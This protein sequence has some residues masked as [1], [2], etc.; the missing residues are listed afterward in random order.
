[1]S[2]LRPS[3]ATTCFTTEG[4]ANF[5]DVTAERGSW[6]VRP[7]QWSTSCAW[8][9][10]DN[11]GQLDLFVCNYVRWSRE[12]DR[13]SD[14]TARR[15]RPRLRAA[16][17]L[18]KARFPTFIATTATG[19]SPMSQRQSGVQIKNSAHRRAHGQIARCRA[20]GFRWRRLDRPDRGQRHR[21]E[22]PLP[23]PDAT[24]RSRKSARITG[25]AY[26][27]AS[28]DVAGRWAST[29]AASETTTTWR[30]PSAISPT[31]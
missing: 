1:M 30:W 29:P 22:L 10:Y 19:T 11:D 21:A 15:R 13:R 6:P 3:A 17:E 16:H 14:Y 31:R 23:Q 9:D 28:A 7:T 8:I 5:T 25:V 27:A 18:S 20:G 12:I 2:S 4:R 24:A 26:R